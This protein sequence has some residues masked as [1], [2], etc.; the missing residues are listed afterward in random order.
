MIQKLSQK[1][2]QQKADLTNR[3]ALLTGGRIKIG[4]LT[5]LRMLR[6]GAKVWVTTRFA[7]DCA[8]RF[9]KEKDFADWAHRLKIVSLDL[10]N[11]VQVSHLI[12]SCRS[13]KRILILSLTMLHKQ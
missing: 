5:A 8:M 3:V 11:L 1:R 6:D 12:N 9:G 4:Y 10:R 7:N 2:R 13:R